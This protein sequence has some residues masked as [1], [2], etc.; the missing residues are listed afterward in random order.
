MR[1]RGGLGEW[2]L[3][4]GPGTAEFNS[5][6]TFVLYFGGFNKRLAKMS[7]MRRARGR[8]GPSKLNE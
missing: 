4:A 7:N 8:R 2:T 1:K 3:E 5:A 6:R